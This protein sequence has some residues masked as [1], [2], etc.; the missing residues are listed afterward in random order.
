M[1]W[2]ILILVTAE[3]IDVFRSVRPN[4]I[5]PLKAQEMSSGGVKPRSGARGAA[6]PWRERRAGNPGLLGKHP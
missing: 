3:N 1:W 4:R 5:N 6:A 2:N